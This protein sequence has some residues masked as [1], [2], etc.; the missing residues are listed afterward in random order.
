MRE[1]RSRITAYIEM[2]KLY[3]ST[4]EEIEEPNSNAHRV[5]FE[6]KRPPPG[7]SKS[8]HLVELSVIEIQ[9]RGSAVSIADLE[10]HV[11]ETGFNVGGQQPRAI[12][13]AYLSRDDRVEY[14]KSQ[15]GWIISTKNKGPAAAGPDFVEGARDGSRGSATHLRFEGSIPSASTQLRRDEVSS[16]SPS[17]SNNPPAPSQGE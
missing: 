10:A 2:D 11:R 1:K 7:L 13:A 12:L 8:A 6:R 16:R 4:E 9:R 17:L 5:T 14:D 3:S 15:N